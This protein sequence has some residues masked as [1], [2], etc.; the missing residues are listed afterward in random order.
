MRKKFIKII[1]FGLLSIFLLC[2]YSRA[3]TIILKNGEA[4]DVNIIEESE[5]N[6]KVEMEGGTVV[7]LKSEVAKIE[8]NEKTPPTA[9]NSETTRQSSPSKGMILV[10]L[11]FLVMGIIIT[12]RRGFF[13]GAILIILGVG[14]LLLNLSKNTSGFTKVSKGRHVD[15]TFGVVFD[16]PEGWYRVKQ[17]PSGT[18]AIFVDNVEKPQGIIQIGTEKIYSPENNIEKVANSLIKKASREFIDFELISR[19]TRIING[20]GGYEFEFKH[21]V[22]G[23]LYEGGCYQKIVVIPKR[24]EINFT[25]ICTTRME[26]YYAIGPVFEKIIDSFQ[27]SKEIPTQASGKTQSDTA[28][29][30]SVQATACCANLRLIDSATGVW[31]MHTEVSKE[32]IPTWEDLLTG[33]PYGY[34]LEKMPEC[35][36]GGNYTVGNFYTPVTCSIGNNNTDFT[37]DDHIL[38]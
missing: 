31:R 6:I 36:R 24:A 28:L 14:L 22:E 23:E 12:K 13:F 9:V 10:G 7:F 35:P 38:K 25:I 20:I 15:R 37:N 29:A 8:K 17:K 2:V 3:D 19:R 21:V 11:F 34:Y 18:L 33:G 5:T 1:L 16:P 32:T 30:R 26:Q 4:L 27:I